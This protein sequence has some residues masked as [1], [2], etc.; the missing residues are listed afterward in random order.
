MKQMVI[1]VFAFFLLFT[2]VQA[3]DS[4]GEAIWIDVRSMGEYQRGHKDDA[5]HIPHTIIGEKIAQVTTD[6]NAEIH[7]YCAAGVR[8]GIAKRTLEKMG[9][10]NVLN[11][12][13]LS[14]VQ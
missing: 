4:T 13:G 8:A 5:L 7:L 3:D 14:D 1:A 12:G 10:T 2:A 9:Y 6:K 11:E